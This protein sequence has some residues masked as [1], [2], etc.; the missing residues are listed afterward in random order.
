MDR[1]Y[2]E[3]L[4]GIINDIQHPVWISD[5]FTYRILAVN[6]TASRLLGYSTE[7]LLKMTILQL[8]SEQ[9]TEYFTSSNKWR[10]YN[11]G[12]HNFF[13]LLTKNGEE[14]FAEMQFKE[15]VYR[16]HNALITTVYDLTER[17]NY[18]KNFKMQQ[19]EISNKNKELNEVFERISD[20]FI[21]LDKHWNIKYINSSALKILNSDRM[22]IGKNFW[23]AFPAYKGTSIENDFRNVLKSQVPETFE[24]EGKNSS[25]WYRISVF[26]SHEGVSIYGVDITLNRAY[27]KNLKD[28]LK[29]KETLLKEVHHR[30]KNNLQIIVSILNLQSYY[31]HDPRTLEIFKQS[32]NRIRSIALIHEKLY[33][34]ENLTS[35][36]LHS[37]LSDIIKFLFSTY[38]VK[39]ENVEAVL[40]MDNIYLDLN[41]AISLGLIVNELVSNSLKYA[42]P[43]NKKGIIKI[44]VRKTAPNMLFEL[45]DNGIGFPAEIDYKNTNSLGLQLVNTLV[46]QL[47]GELQLVYNEGTKFRIVLPYFDNNTFR[48]KQDYM[49]KQQ[50]DH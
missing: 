46:E 17:I 13:K 16:K 24:I 50:Y 41:T 43:A 10:M 38:L 31:I 26:P 27:E 23:D 36:D 19:E 39:Q 33:K 42:F 48:I 12:M 3:D 30:I 14:I 45:S 35:V 29:Q 2:K 9:E 40:D 47:N 21:A 32:Q 5:K 4:V 11:Y 7:E 20:A 25:R 34:T 6:R 37:Y 15:T 22:V 18:E 49:I 8:R 28:T 1:L 44:L